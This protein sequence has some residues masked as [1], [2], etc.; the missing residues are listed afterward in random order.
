M[1]VLYISLAS[2]GVFLF[3]IWLN[4]KLSKEAQEAKDMKDQFSEALKRAKISK[5]IRSGPDLDDD[6]LHY[7]D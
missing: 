7:R 5:D 3:L 4:T 1:S 2:L 6:E